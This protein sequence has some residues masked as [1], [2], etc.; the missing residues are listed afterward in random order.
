MSEILCNICG[1]NKI[2]IQYEQRQIIVPYSNP[3]YYDAEVHTCETCHESTDVVD[4]NDQLHTEA[5]HKVLLKS[6]INMLKL[7][8]C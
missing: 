2:I 8:C 1:S 4:T 6:V 3:V 5:E 7:L